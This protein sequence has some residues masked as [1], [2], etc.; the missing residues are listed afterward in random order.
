MAAESE[1]L[2]RAQAAEIRRRHPEAPVIGIRL[3]EPAE[4]GA[5]IRVNGEELPVA[6]CRSVLEARQRILEAGG[7]P[8]VLL[9]AE[10]DAPELGDDLLARLARRRL[11][12]IDPWGLVRDRFRATRIDPRLYADGKDLLARAL[13][14]ALEGRP[15]P[16]PAPSGFLAAETVWGVLFETLLGLEG[17]ACDAEALLRWGLARQNVE[18]LARLGEELQD[19]LAHAVAESAGPAAAAVF[20]CL[21]GPHPEQALSIGLV[22]QA[23]FAEEAQTDPELVRAAVRMEAFCGGER[24]RGQVARAWADAAEAVVEALVREQGLAGVRLHLEAAGRFLRKDLDA[25]TPAEVSRYLPQSLDAR[26]EAF[27]AAL[28]AALDGVRKELL[29]AWAAADRLGEH[30]LVR[31]S[32]AVREHATMALRLTHWL[33]KARDHKQAASL[34]EAAMRY[35][36]EESYVDLA[37]SFVVDAD[38]SPALREGY[39]A[40]R[41]AATEA[42]EAGSRRFAELLAGW[43]ETASRDG[44]VLPVEEVLAHVV[45]PL[46]RQGPVLLLVMDGMSAAVYRELQQDLV[47]EHWVELVPEE[48]GARRPV[49]AALPSVTKVSRASLFAGKLAVGTQREEVRAFEGHSAL[50]SASARGKAPRIFHKAS[51]SEGGVLAEEVRE[52]LEDRE[53]RVVAVVVNAIDDHLAKGDQLR[54]AWGLDSIRPL[55]ALLDRAAMAQRAVVLVSDHGHVVDRGT[56]AGEGEGERWRPL[57]GELR[58]EEVGLAGPR[59]LLGDGAV[60]A[61]WTEQVRYGGKKHG[62]HGGASPQEV[63]IPLAISLAFGL[64]TATLLILFVIPAFYMVLYDFGLFHRHEELKPI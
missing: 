16:K 35:R 11:H 48:T 24:L 29:A 52:A 5:R 6:W 44:A 64:T 50:R 30:V 62:Y 46:A 3:P 25:K 7:E 63:V 31:E 9:T 58:P 28:R 23:L 15:A 53:Q 57:E 13:L 4:V 17:G 54:M 22:A 49:L 43:T 47:A 1:A 2:I 39:A 18:R 34:V 27:A 38:G 8:L 56:T 21:A 59:V 32:D 33:A 41:G 14:A 55:R 45:A 51:L 12:P 19:A 10:L 42:R 20:A 60:A 61:P 40:L 37:R 26:Q 36:Q